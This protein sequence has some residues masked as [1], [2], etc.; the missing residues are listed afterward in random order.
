MDFKSVYVEG[1]NLDEVWFK[2][3]VELCNYGRYYRIDSGSF[4]GDFRLEFD[5]VDGLIKTPIEY[6]VYGTR[7][8]LAVSV[9][10]GCPPP[11]TDKEIQE[12]F[13][14]YLMNSELKE[15][16]HYKYATFIVGGDYQIPHIS[17]KRPFVKVKQGE[18]FTFNRRPSKIKEPTLVIEVPNQ[19]QWCID[20]YLEK[21]FGNNHCCMAIA[22]P[23]SNSAYDIPYKTEME[24]HTSPCL[25]LIDTKITYHPEEED[26]HLRYRL[27]FYVYF[28]SQDLWGGWPTNY[29]GI[30]LLLEEMAYRIGILPGVIKFGSKGLHVYGHTI[31]PLI[32]RSGQYDLIERLENI[33]LYLGIKEAA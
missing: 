28:R 22:Y 14:N 3:L 16:E 33:K 21:G 17:L 25:R 8:P 5:N 20:H 18:S 7:K 23:E 26:E 30:A 31:E 6:T 11:T 4:A 24:R 15:N 12:Y 9:P 32:M 10:A 27:N 19:M 1:R 2:L 13:E 29:G